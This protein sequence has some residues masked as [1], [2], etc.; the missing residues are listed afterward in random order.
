VDEKQVLEVKHDRVL[1]LG[2]S[3]GVEVEHRASHRFRVEKIGRV[4]VC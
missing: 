3:G 4:Q 2:V 1:V